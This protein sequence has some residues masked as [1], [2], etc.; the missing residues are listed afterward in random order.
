MKRSTGELKRRAKSDLQGRYGTAILAVFA[1]AALGGIGSLLTGSLFPGESTVSIVSGQIFQFVLSL[2]SGIF[3]AGCSYMLLN[4]SRGREYGLGDL[5]YFFHHHPDRVIVAGFALGMINTVANIPYYY[6]SYTT[7]MGETLEQQMIWMSKT[8]GALLLGTVLGLVLT[9]PFAMTYFLMADDLEL[10][11]FQGLKESLGMMKG[12]VLRYLWLEASFI[13][14]L[15]L[16]AFT[17]Y[18]ALI[19]IMPYMEMTFVCFYR[20]LKG[21]LD[22]RPSLP[23]DFPGPFYERCGEDDYNS[24]A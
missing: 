8:T 13:P 21:E 9:I 10:G 23:Q 6:V 3:S 1:V 2:I 11:G 17:L 15:F 16:S 7:P 19:W 18:L 22:Q 14:L 20:D 5:L 4:I 12:N 24:E